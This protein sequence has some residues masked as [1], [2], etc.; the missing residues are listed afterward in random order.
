MDRLLYSSPQPCPHQQPFLT[1]HPL[2]TACRVLAFGGILIA[3][4]RFA[5]IQMLHTAAAAE[6]QRWQFSQL[7]AAFPASHLHIRREIC[8]SCKTVNQYLGSVVKAA[9]FHLAVYILHS[10]QPRLTVMAANCSREMTPPNGDLP[11]ATAS[12]LSSVFS[13]SLSCSRLHLFATQRQ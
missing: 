12:R 11:A 7:G 5:P 3:Q 4:R 10:A 2:A 13:A 1:S 8:K 6:C 9:T